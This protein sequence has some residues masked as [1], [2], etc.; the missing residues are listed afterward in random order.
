MKH[1]NIENLRDVI[2][3]NHSYEVTRREIECLYYLS[4]GKS[5]KQIASTL[6]ISSRTVEFHLKNLR[7]K[8]GAK[9]RLQLLNHLSLI[10]F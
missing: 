8:T 5:S 9:N 3:K 6:N 4:L 1:T 10:S 7:N 2:L